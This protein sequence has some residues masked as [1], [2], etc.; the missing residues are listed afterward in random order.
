MS[1]FL[2]V[3]FIAD[4]GDVKERHIPNLDSGVIDGLQR[5]LHDGNP[6]VNGLK[7]ALDYVSDDDINNYKFAINADR[8]PNTRRYISEVT[9]LLVDQKCVRKVYWNIV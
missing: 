3:Y 2:Q 5:I 7:T 4:Y 1:K 9:E 8:R 6:Y